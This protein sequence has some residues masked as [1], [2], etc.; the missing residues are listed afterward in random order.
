MSD[1][2]CPW[3]ICNHQQAQECRTVDG[4]KGCGG[5]FPKNTTLEQARQMIGPRP[6]ATP[7]GAGDGHTFIPRQLTEDDVRRI[8]REELAAQ[9]K[10]GE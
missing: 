4:H 7:V 5:I 6:A 10:G 3:G 1:W 8:V 2:V 9:G